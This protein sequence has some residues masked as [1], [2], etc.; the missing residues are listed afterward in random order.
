[1]ISSSR[2]AI[3]CIL[4]LWPTIIFA[5]SQTVSDKEA[6]GTVSGKVTVKGNGV[7][8]V[9]VGLINSQQRFHQ[10]PVQKAVTGEDGV[11]RINNVKP[12]AYELAV[13]S[14]TYVTAGSS[15]ARKALIVV[16][17][18]TIENVDFNLVRG[19]VITGRV[20]DS[21]GLPV[22]E[23]NV[24]I[25]QAQFQHRSSVKSSLRTDDRGIYRAFGLSP[26]S[27]I[28]STGQEENSM[29]GGSIT[30]Y[31]HRLAY[32]PAAAERSQATVIEVTEGS[33]STGVDIT[34]G[35]SMVRYFAS[36][37]IVD[38]ETGKPLAGVSY[39][40]TRFAKYGFEGSR[41]GGNNTNEQGEF[42]LTGLP[43]GSYA[44]SAET[45]SG[46][47]LRV[48]P[49]RF[50]VIDRDVTGL[51]VK[52]TRGGSISGEVILEVADS[53]AAVSNDRGFLTAMVETR[54]GVRDVNRSAR[55]KPDGTFHIGGLQEGSL[56]LWVSSRNDLQ[57]IRV[58]RDG[59]VYPN[60][61]EIKDLEQMTGLRIIVSNA[62]GM[63]RGIVKLVNGSPPPENLVSV[64]LKK[65][66]DDPANGMIRG[67]QLDARG[68]FFADR[69]LPGTYELTATIYSRASLEGFDSRLKK[70]TQQV[71]V[72][73][74]NVSSVTITLPEQ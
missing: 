63:V 24:S 8:G 59:V 21:E 45:D 71:V 65:L 1:M 62:T 5:Q 30:R 40:V 16:K 31:E 54:N 41:I 49:H 67:V 50:E 60:R 26:G 34:L 70:T 13:S 39:G 25:S 9:V 4:L 44:V 43:P 72:T 12:G 35:G 73:N 48:E 15:Y 64:T 14:L 42:K 22:I 66:N 56:R 61:I 51:I 36:G 53:K 68:Q 32:H 37:R 28:V 19:G 74:D 33:E 2:Q 46:S 18:E 10:A 17:G 6:N 11:Y 29:F 58:E 47:D 38:A 69:L 55:I 23:I 3:A 52:T 57:I 7:S 27:Y 20:I